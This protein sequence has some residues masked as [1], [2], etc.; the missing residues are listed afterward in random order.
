M[1]NHESGQWLL[2][3][4]RMAYRAGAGWILDELDKIQYNG[5]PGEFVT[6]LAVRAQELRQSLAVAEREDA[7]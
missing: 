1:N 7:E 3:R 4:E 5:D 2:L 6:A